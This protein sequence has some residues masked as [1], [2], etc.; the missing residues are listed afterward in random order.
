M[1]LVV[2]NLPANAGD[3]RDSGSILGLERSPGG[4]LGNPLQYSCLE[5]PMHREAWRATV[6]R[7]AKSRIQL[8]DWTIISAC[9]KHLCV[10]FKF[11]HIWTP[12]LFGRIPIQESWLIEWPLKK[13]RKCHRVEGR[14]K[15]IALH[16]E[17]NKLWVI[18]SSL[19]LHIYVDIIAII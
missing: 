5:N 1:A 15:L 12:Y 2:K 3:T 13:F 4:E 10:F 9:S 14:Q 17:Q 18:S 19:L 7:V 6:H 11:S 16:P 8:S